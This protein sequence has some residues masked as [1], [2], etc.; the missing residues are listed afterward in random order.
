MIHA[1]E[2]VLFA[3][4][5]LLTIEEARRIVA[6]QPQTVEHAAERRARSDIL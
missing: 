2:M 3:R 6:D 5:K 4:G 1:A